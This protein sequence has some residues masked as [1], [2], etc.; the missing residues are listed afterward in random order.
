MQAFEDKAWPCKCVCKYVQDTWKISWACS[1]W[2]CISSLATA[3]NV[4]KRRA[5]W[6]TWLPLLFWLQVI[7]ATVS[8]KIQNLEF[9]GQWVIIHL[10]RFLKKQFLQWIVQQWDQCGIVFNRCWII[11]NRIRGKWC[12]DYKPNRAKTLLFLQTFPFEMNTVKK[13]F[14]SS[15]VIP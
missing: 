8:G 4:T 14:C 11:Q 12:R 3:G 13:Y 10:Y 1:S 6:G 15:D 9:E 5:V 7:P 2:F